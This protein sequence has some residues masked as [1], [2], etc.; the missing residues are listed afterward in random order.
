VYSVV[1]VGAVPTPKPFTLPKPVDQL[2]E[3]PKTV[4]PPLAFDIVCIC[5]A[6]AHPARMKKKT[7]K[8]FDGW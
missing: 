2:G 6:Q 1:P 7:T 3:L 4:I 8:A 5:W